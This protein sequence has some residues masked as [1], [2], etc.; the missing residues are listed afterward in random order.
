MVRLLTEIEAPGG[1]KL[2]DYKLSRT[3]TPVP[4]GCHGVVGSIQV[5]AV[6]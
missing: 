3:F 6:F 4:S 1:R 2:Q 5:A